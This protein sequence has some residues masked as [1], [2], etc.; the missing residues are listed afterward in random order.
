MAD[1]PAG[2]ADSGVQ[3]VLTEQAT[4]FI[5]N[6]SVPKGYPYPYVRA[7]ANTGGGKPEPYVFEL[8]QN[9]GSK[10][11]LVPFLKKSEQTGQY[12]KVVLLN[13]LNMDEIYNNRPGEPAK[14]GG[15]GFDWE[16]GE[17]ALRFSLNEAK[18][19]IQKI[20][21][22]RDYADM[23][24]TKSTIAGIPTVEMYVPK[25]PEK[26]LEVPAQSPLLGSVPAEFL[27][28][29]KSG[30]A[31]GTKPDAQN[32]TAPA[33]EVATKPITL[34]DL[35]QANILP[36]DDGHMEL[37]YIHAKKAISYLAG[38]E[39]E[40]QVQQAAKILTQEYQTLESYA[41][42]IQ[43]FAEEP[44]ERRAGQVDNYQTAISAFY[45]EQKTSM[46]DGFVEGGG[47]PDET[48]ERLK[49]VR[50]TAREFMDTVEEKLR[51]IDPADPNWKGLTPEERRTIMESLPTG[52][53][54]RQKVRDGLSERMQN[55]DEDARGAAKG[56]VDETNAHA[57]AAM[58]Q[59]REGMEALGSP[60]VQKQIE[61]LRAQQEAAARETAPAREAEVCKQL[62]NNPVFAA[63]CAPKT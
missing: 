2:S 27:Q 3:A 24:I 51:Q 23:Q 29:Y 53:E 14:S 63:Q 54:M 31:Q 49:K 57:D 58:K 5:K 4:G 11:Y 17:E 60:Q 35:E 9:D 50:P 19:K 46:A 21:G 25:A 40:A 52:D 44:A 39:N 36:S 33:S 12:D 61:E 32:M 48:G 18:A 13:G 20:A 43:R 26:L 15:T 42:T 59:Y 1:F 45:Y 56:Q 30:G 6:T 28:Q 7:Q 41:L 22:N 8:T 38:L 47:V 55:A 10:E 62:A 34:K 16:K 37:D